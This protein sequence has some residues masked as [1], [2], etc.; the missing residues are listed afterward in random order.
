MLTKSELQERYRRIERQVDEI[1]RTIGVR[2][3]KLS[4]QL[5]IEEMAP[6]SPGGVA[7][8]AAS[9]CEL[10]GA[11]LP[12][13]R[14]RQELDHQLDLLDVEGMQA[15]SKAWAAIMGFAGEAQK[16]DTESEIDRAKK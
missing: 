16:G 13:A 14:D 3:L 5:R 2:R 9:V 11:P 4:E 7:L 10:D 15:A 8:I 12:M 1:G 6:N